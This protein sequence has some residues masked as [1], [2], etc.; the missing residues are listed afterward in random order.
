MEKQSLH[1]RSLVCS[2]ISYIF[3]EARKDSATEIQWSSEE[4]KRVYT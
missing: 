1:M 3:K 4:I 2:D